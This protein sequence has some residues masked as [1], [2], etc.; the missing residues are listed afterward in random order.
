[1]KQPSTMPA[2]LFITASDV[3]ALADRLE[4]R[5]TN[6]AMR[7]QENLQHDLR[8]AAKAI[9]ALLRDRGPGD[10]IICDES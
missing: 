5:G 1:M 3:H 4:L 9:R 2:S 10:Q 8:L 6:R 7:N